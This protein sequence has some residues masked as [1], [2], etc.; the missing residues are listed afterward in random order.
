[1]PLRLPNLAFDKCPDEK[2]IKPSDDGRIKIWLNFD[3]CPDEKGI[4]PDI[5]Y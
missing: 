1:M 2:G 5:G 4:K 3:K